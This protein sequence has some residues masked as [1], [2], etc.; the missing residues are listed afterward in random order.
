VRE[1]VA[2]PLGVAVPDTVPGGVLEGVLV[3]DAVGE[4]VAVPLAVAVGDEL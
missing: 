4:A 1:A 2:V 3:A